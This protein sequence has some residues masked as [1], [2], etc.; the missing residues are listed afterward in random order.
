MERLL[1]I[2]DEFYE[3]ALL[4]NC[5]TEKRASR[6]AFLADLRK[7]I[8]GREAYLA[9]MHQNALAHQAEQDGWVEEVKRVCNPS[10]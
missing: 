10:R 5:S 3:A 6:L 8:A 2:I 1:Q 7:F 9:V 4:E